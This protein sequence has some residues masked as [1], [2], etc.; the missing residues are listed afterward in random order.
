MRL[1]VELPDDDLTVHVVEVVGL[2]PKSP[3]DA[4]WRAVSSVLNPAR[5]VVGLD[6]A[7]QSIVKQDGGGEFRATVKVAYTCDPEGQRVAPA[8][9][10]RLQ[11]GT[12]TRERGSG[13]EPRSP[14]AAC[15]PPAGGGRVG[16]DLRRRRVVVR[17]VDAG[18]SVCEVAC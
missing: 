2:S 11:S 10:C 8:L 6:V 18:A 9:T 17:G 3:S 1:D 5:H 16:G 13:C 15:P 4:V 12:D 14:G 7:D